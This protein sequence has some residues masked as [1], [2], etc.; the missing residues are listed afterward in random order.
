MQRG[1]GQVT[2]Y[3]KML[4]DMLGANWMEGAK[5]H[6]SSK[7]WIKQCRPHMDSYIAKL[8]IPPNPLTKAE[9]TQAVTQ[10]N[11]HNNA[12]QPP[13]L[14]QLTPHQSRKKQDEANPEKADD[15]ST[16]G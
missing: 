3:D 5:L 14:R 10:E 8:G 12:T 4:I 11:L 7:S 16:E 1:G 9:D 15:R 13:L 2:P 6:H